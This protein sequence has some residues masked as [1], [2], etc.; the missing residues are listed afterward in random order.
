MRGN[1]PLAIQHF[2]LRERG[3]GDE[4]VE[5]IVFTI[6]FM[7]LAMIAAREIAATGDTHRA[8]PAP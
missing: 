4:P 1:C 2:A 7:F 8:K 5:P 6:V 3:H